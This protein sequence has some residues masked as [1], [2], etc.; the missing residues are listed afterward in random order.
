M[1]HQTSSVQRHIPPPVNQIIIPTAASNAAQTVVGWMA[2]ITSS[3]Y[4]QAFLWDAANGLQPLQDILTTQMASVQPQLGGKLE[5]ATAITPDGQTIL[6]NGIDPQGKSEPWI[7][8]LASPKADIV[9]LAVSVAPS[10]KD[11]SVDLTADYRIDVPRRSRG[12]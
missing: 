2:R 4:S 7:V 6:G 11:D 5:Q 9:A 12:R 3:L 8:H 1:A 10:G